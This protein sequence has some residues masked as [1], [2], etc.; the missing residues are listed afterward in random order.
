MP[1]DLL[2]LSA[3]PDDAELSCA[4]TILSYT[5]KGRTAGIVDFTRG[6]LGTRGNAKIRMEEAKKAATVLKL[7]AR[8]NLGFEDGFFGTDKAHITELI[9]MIRK[10]RPDI[11]LANAPDDRH[12]DHG[13]GGLLAEK[14]CFL[15]GLIKMKTSMGGKTQEAWRPRQIFHYMQD[16]YIKPDFVMDITPYWKKKLEAISAYKSQFY[17]P[18]SKEPSTYISTPEFM[19]YIEARA[20]ESGRAI[21]VKYGEGFLTKRQVGIKDLKDLI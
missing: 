17:D 14:A 6:E 11:V 12:P 15:S 5:M 8:E 19:K 3:H 16:R 21:G 2:V 20:L 10:F 13:Q 4:G 7:S 1:L 9:R 18:S